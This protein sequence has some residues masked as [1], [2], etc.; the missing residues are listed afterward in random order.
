M[1]SRPSAVFRGVEAQPAWLPVAQL[2][3]EL[4]AEERMEGTM[5]VRDSGSREAG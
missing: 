5:A 3:P 2:I 4:S 1:V